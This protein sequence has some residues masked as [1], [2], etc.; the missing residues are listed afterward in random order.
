MLKIGKTAAPFLVPTNGEPQG[1]ASTVM[2]CIALFSVLSRRLHN[3]AACVD[4]YVYFDDSQTTVEQQN[5]E[6]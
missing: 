4:T 6:P 3:V 1:L 2:R 5:F